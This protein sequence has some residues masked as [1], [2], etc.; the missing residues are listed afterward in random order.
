MSRL[1]LGMYF[2]MLPQRAIWWRADTAMSC[3]P[4]VMVPSRHFMSSVWV[5]K[6]VDQNRQH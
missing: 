1:C 2:A 3:F 5:L 4:P 6:A